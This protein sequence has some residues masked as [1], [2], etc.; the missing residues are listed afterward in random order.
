V[1]LCKETYHGQP[2]YVSGQEKG[3]KKWNEGD[4]G[5]VPYV[6]LT[7]PTYSKITSN[8]DVRK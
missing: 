5:H 7:F 6:I 4:Q 1:Q 2:A 3:I 8:Q